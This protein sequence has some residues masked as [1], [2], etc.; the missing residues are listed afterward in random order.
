M[1]LTH[2]VSLC[3]AGPHCFPHAPAG[4]EVL[5]IQ[6]SGPPQADILPAAGLVRNLSA[7]LCLRELHLCKLHLLHPI[8]LCDALANVHLLRVLVLDYVEAYEKVS[9]ALKWAMTCAALWTAS[10]THSLT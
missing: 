10:C 5:A 9:P 2:P 8:V 3:F 6:Q 7:A 4:P 1:T